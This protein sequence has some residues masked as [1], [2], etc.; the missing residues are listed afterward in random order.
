MITG[1]PN[2]RQRRTRWHSR[3]GLTVA[4]NY[5]LQAISA[6][7]LQDKDERVNPL[8]ELTLDQL[9]MR[10]SVKWRTYPSDVLPMFI[11]EMDTPLAPAIA[12][13]LVESVSLGDTG[14]ATIGRLGEAYAGFAERRY[15]W[16]PD[17]GTMLLVPDVNHGI[18]E[19][20]RAVSRPGDA[21][22]LDTPAYPPFF[23]T[24][25]AAEHTVVENPMRETAEGFEIDLDGLERA[26]AAGAKVYLL[27]NPHNPTG[28]VL[29]ADTLAAV[30]AL[31]DKYGVRVLADEI[32]GPM[33]YPGVKHVPFQT[34][35]APA[36]ASA[37]TF[38]SASKAWNLPGL[39]AALAIPG[40][41]AVDSV[42][43]IDALAVSAG[44]HGVLASEVAFTE[45]LLW[46]EDLMS[47]LDHNRMRLATR[48]AEEL[49]E[50]RYRPPDATYLAW[51]DLRAFD[52]GDDP[53]VRIL[54]RGRLALHSG[55][56]FGAAGNGFARLNF[57]AR[58]ELIDEAV[59]RIAVAVRP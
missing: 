32:H 43:S 40:P 7:R 21:V 17:P 52:L 15:G 30:A 2:C 50:I 37:I 47:G 42:A 14:Y 24:V 22:V 18:C 51:L 26:F 35:A 23:S 55:S 19:V 58:P 56:A 46:L 5:R 8:T 3:R 38:V 49:P 10:R 27:C 57:A 53:A 54:D 59:R 9:R 33:T 1:T 36:A 28:T 20:L 29:T 6:C 39:K 44:L 13:A 11:A 31:A 16:S 12:S 41:D 4:A 25:Q 34:I 48:L 45:G